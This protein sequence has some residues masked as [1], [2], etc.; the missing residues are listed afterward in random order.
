MKTEKEAWQSVLD[1]EARRWSAMP[2]E[3]LATR[4]RKLAAYEVEFQQKK[5]QVE[6]ELLRQGDQHLEIMIA[7]DDGILP[8]S[9]LPMMRIISREKFPSS[10]P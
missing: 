5:Y 8:R 2:L 10:R 1:A 4:L 9:L 7:V 6:V 3:E